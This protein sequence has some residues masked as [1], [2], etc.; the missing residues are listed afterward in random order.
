MALSGQV[1]LGGVTGQ[2]AAPA[3]AASSSSSLSSSV[4]LFA[5]G[6]GGYRTG[7]ISPARLFDAINVILAFHNPDG[8]WATY[9]EMRGAGEDV[10]GARMR[11]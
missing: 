6:Y 7:H 1:N 5:D 2:T 9:E 8:G 3:A 10:W 4:S 11:C